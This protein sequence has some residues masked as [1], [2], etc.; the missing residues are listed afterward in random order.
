[1]L[2]A[3]YETGRALVN[4]LCRLRQSSCSLLRAPFSLS[5]APQLAS[6]FVF[7]TT[8]SLR[9]LRYSAK[10]QL[11]LAHPLH[12]RVAASPAANSTAGLPASQATW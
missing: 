6:L 2:R 11:F 12:F 9:R 5:L 1:M 3:R 4:I 7:V 10:T 8:S